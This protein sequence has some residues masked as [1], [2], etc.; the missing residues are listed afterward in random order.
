MEGRVGWGSSARTVGLK[1]ARRKSVLKWDAPKNH[2]HPRVK[3]GVSEEAA[4]LPQRCLDI[5]PLL[6]VHGLCGAH[7]GRHGPRPPVVRG[8]LAHQGRYEDGADHER[9]EQHRHRQEQPELVQLGLA[10]RQEAAEC[11]A[12]DDARPA[13]RRPGPAHAHHHRLHVVHPRQ[14]V[15]QHPR[16]QEDVVVQ[17]QRH[18]HWDHHR[19]HRVRQPLVL[20][21]RQVREQ[22]PQPLRLVHQHRH[23]QRD[24][25]RVR[26]REREPQRQQQRPEHEAHDHHHRHADHPHDERDVRLDDVRGVDVGAVVRRKHHLEGSPVTGVEAVHHV[27]HGVHP[28]A[29]LGAVDTEGCGD[30]GSRDVAIA[31]DC[32]FHESSVLVAHRT[33]HVHELHCFVVADGR[34]LC[35]RDSSE[36]VP[37]H[38]PRLVVEAGKGAVGQLRHGFEACWRHDLVRL[39]HAHEQQ[40]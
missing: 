28:R 39:V 24:R 25:N 6:N 38:R 36:N 5:Q 18:A 12:H 4:S 37:A 1:P 7:H 20:V 2:S 3:E 31:R 16:Q 40:V 33:R 9:V 35:K 15:F 27:T 34:A 21:L 19:W 22:P 26:E 13:D 30:D 8:R 14:P 29:S 32:L 23:P 10:R 11:H 17:P